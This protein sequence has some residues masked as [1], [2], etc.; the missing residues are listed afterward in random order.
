MT[1]LETIQYVGN[2]QIFDLNANS[3]S[4]AYKDSDGGNERSGSS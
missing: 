2:T 3:P 1:R 4:G